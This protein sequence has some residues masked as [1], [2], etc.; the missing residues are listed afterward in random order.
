MNALLKK[1]WFPALSITGAILF[2]WFLIADEKRI[3]ARTQ[4]MT[5]DLDMRC[6]YLGNRLT[7]TWHPRNVMIWDCEGVHVERFVRR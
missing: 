7:D 4:A 3:Q 2:A 1:T 6:T 5:D